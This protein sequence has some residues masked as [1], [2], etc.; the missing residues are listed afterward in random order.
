[1]RRAVLLLAVLVVAG[2]GG[3]ATHTAPPLPHALALRWAQQAA[4]IAAADPCTAHRQAAVLRTAVILAINKQ[5]IPQR[6]LEPLT[7]KVN[8]L[9]AHQA[10]APVQREA[11]DL[12]AWLRNPSS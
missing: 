10:C 5:Q 6:L 3:A 9:A 4:A 12:A 7:S 8:A 2:C 11:H 1:M